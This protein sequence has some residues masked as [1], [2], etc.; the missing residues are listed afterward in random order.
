MA[1]ASE[2]MPFRVICEIRVR[3]KSCVKREYFYIC[4]FPDT[5]QALDRVFQPQITQI[6]SPRMLSHVYLPYTFLAGAILSGQTHKSRI[7]VIGAGQTHQ[8]YLQKSSIYYHRISYL[9]TRISLISQK[10]RRFARACRRSPSVFSRMAHT[11]VSA[12]DS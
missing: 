4:V 10:A 12:C 2:M 1:N 8:K 6:F 11:S 5:T 9:F 3:Q 7:R